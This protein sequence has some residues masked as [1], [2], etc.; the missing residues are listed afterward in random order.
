V[1]QSVGVGLVRMTAPELPDLV[2]ALSMLRLDT[3]AL[4]GSLT[5]AKSP[6]D[7]KSRI[8]VWPDLGDALPIMRRIKQQ[9]DPNRILSPGRFVGDI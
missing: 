4:G 3:G 5:L 2:H 7:I 9:F 6:A 8:D 1:G